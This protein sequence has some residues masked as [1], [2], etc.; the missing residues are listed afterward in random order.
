[1]TRKLLIAAVMAG[2]V[3]LMVT[4]PLRLALVM[5][6]AEAA[7]LSARSVTGSIWSGQMVDAG[8]RGAELGTI[9]TALAPMALL[10]GDV[11]VDFVRN[12]AMRG[13]LRGGVYLN[14]GGGLSDVNGKLSLGS[15]LA[16]V[17]LD[18]VQLDGVGLRFDRHGRCHD[19]AGKMQ[20][21][22][23]LP[24]PGLD[25]SNGLSG[26]IICR[27]GRAE[28]ALVSQ[29]GMEQLRFGVDGQGA[30][31]AQLSVSVG[32][33]PLLAGLLRSAGF[34]PAGDSLILVRQGRL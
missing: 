10:G 1:M 29:S 28:A 32:T 30:W 2:L 12:D 34:L 17:P 13:A 33:D 6:G 14:G 26:P 5:A 27:N 31:R 15:S 25:L 20:L 19:A 18:Q 8:W 7:G 9:D 22:V 23:V 4:F 21:T 24:V 3:L 11:R 16:G